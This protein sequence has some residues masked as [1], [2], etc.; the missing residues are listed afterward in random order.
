AR[1]RLSAAPRRR[2]S[3][4]RRRPRRPLPR[5]VR[6]RSRR[7][8]SPRRSARVDARGGAAPAASRTRPAPAPPRCTPRPP[9][10]ARPPPASR[11]PAALVLPGLAILLASRADVPAP[12]PGLAVAS[13]AFAD[14]VAL[15]ALFG[16]A[17]ALGAS[18]SPADRPPPTG[19]AVLVSAAGLVLALLAPG[20]GPY[21][22]I[23][24]AAAAVIA[25]ELWRRSIA[26]AGPR[27]AL[28]PFRLT[29]AAALLLVLVAAP[30]HA[31]ARAV[32]ASRTAAA[33]RLPD[34]QRISAS[35]VVA[36]R[37]SV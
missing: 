12:V 21:F 9:P 27:G 25:Y 37:R 5:D 2:I 19:L 28:G 29:A 17:L 23:A 22:P 15:T 32:A 30:C 33:I 18:A 24:V 6:R 16:A 34:P 36:L 1:R 14:L 13:E 20:S 35:A 11:P 26:A 4:G 8:A 10:A 7:L 3:V 31:H